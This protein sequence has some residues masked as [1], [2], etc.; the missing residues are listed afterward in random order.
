[1]PLAYLLLG[2]NLGDRK[3]YI[4]QAIA[5]IQN[6]CGNIVKTSSIYETA[7]WGIE[8]QPNF[9]N[10]IVIC[11]TTLLTNILLQKLLKIEFD[12]GRLRT[13]KN[14]SR[15][16]DID[17]LFYGRTILNEENL[18]IPHPKIAERKFVLVPLFEM[19]PNKIHPVLNISIKKLLTICSDTLL[20]TKLD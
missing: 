18:Q 8:D 14:A 1:M 17:I 6:V 7:S 9:L 2:T 20:V 16:I 13:I 19:T 12:L 3:K 5:A 10:Q 4:Q 11:K 15:T